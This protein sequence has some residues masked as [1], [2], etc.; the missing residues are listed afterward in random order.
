MKNPITVIKY[1]FTYRKL[2]LKHRKYLAKQYGFNIDRVYRLWTVIDLSQIPKELEEKFGVDAVVE[3]EMKKY[4]H[5]FNKD[6]PSLELDELINFYELKPLENNRYGITFGYK[7]YNNALLFV[8]FIS[9]LI[10]ALG[11]LAFLII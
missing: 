7:L 8:W 9:I 11:S 3:M 4:I 10:L 5:L 1:F 2:I 6:I